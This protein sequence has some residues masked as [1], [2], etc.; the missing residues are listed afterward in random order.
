VLDI[1]YYVLTHHIIG[2]SSE[3]L[4]NSSI[5]KSG[6]E[7][8][9]PITG[10]ENSRI[11]HTM[12]QNM[13]SLTIKLNFSFGNDGQ[14]SYLIIETESDYPNIK[15]RSNG[16]QSPNVSLSSDDSSAASVFSSSDSSEE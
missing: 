7:S 13:R 3:N 11:Q 1:I 16:K 4:E 9:I 6:H 12:E 10:S 15:I 8:D 5:N 2:K 14:N